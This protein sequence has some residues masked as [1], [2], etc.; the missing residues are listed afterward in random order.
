MNNAPNPVIRTTKLDAYPG[1]I[2]REYADGTFDATDRRA[3]SW[4]CDAFAHAVAA[5]RYFANGE[6]D[7]LAAV[8]GFLH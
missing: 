2:V 7:D 1:W 6:R 8:P 3:L 5:A 4:A